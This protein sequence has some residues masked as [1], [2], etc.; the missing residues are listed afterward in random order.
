LN[1]EI[2]QA[3]EQNATALSPLTVSWKRVRKSEFPEQKVLSAVGLADTALE[4]MAPEKVRFMWQGGKFY[5]CIWRNMPE[6]DKDGHMLKAKN[7]IEIPQETS[8]DLEKYYNGNPEPQGTNKPADG[9]IQIDFIKKI[10]EEKS[11]ARICY[12]EYL[13]L[14]G[15]QLP[16]TP[17]QLMAE[18]PQ[19]LSLAFLNGGG[20]VTEI[21]TEQIDGSPMTAVGITK[22][23]QRSRFV[24]D[25]A[26]HYALRRRTITYETN[27]TSATTDCQDFIKLPNSHLWLPRR[28]EI[29]QNYPKATGPGKPLFTETMTVTEIHNDPIP[30]AQFVLNYTKPGTHISDAT[31]PGAGSSKSRRISYVVP[32]NPEDLAAAI[33]TATEGLASPKSKLSAIALWLNIAIVIL[34]VVFLFYRRWK[35][36]G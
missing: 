34:I 4:F 18:A 3:L 32:A 11:S 28:F 10:A 22:D 26:R 20:K 9:V 1:P 27:D 21:A 36:A 8:F 33:R 29:A 25:P 16:A 14:A 15:F 35:H 24:F 12:A 17:H 23:G 19:A 6:L 2:R 7:V 5:S 30:D 31:L 13:Y